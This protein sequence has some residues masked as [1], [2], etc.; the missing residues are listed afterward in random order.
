[1]EP[2]RKA[3]P[4]ILALI[5]N[6]PLVKL[7]RIRVKPGVEIWAK[8]ESFNPG[9]SVKDRIAL[10]MIEDAEQKGL[11]TPGK[12][13]AEASSG[14]T[15]I[16]LAMVCAVKGYRC[17]IAM[18]ESASVERRKIMQA[19]GAEI[20]LT[21]AEKSTDGAIEA[22]YEL[23]RRYPDKYYNPDQFNNPANWQMHYRTTGPEIWRDTEGRVTHVVASMGTTGTL[24]G[25][26]RYFREKAPG[27]RVIGVEPVPG[28][29]IQGLKNMKESYPPGIY[30]RKLP[31]AVVNVDDE[32]AYELARRLAREEGIFVGMSSG[33]ALAGALRVAREIEQGLIV[34]IFPDGGERYLS[35]PLWVFPAPPRREDF[36]I[37]NTLTGKK[38]VF[39][40]LEAGKVRIYTCGPTL[41]RRPHLGLYR[42]MLTADVLRRWLEARG[43][44]VTHVV[45]LTDFD[46]KTLAAA[47]A[48]GRPLRELT[49]E[50]AREF[51]EDLAFLRIKPAT[52]YPRVSEHLEDMLALTR[53]LLEKGL[54]YE[55]YSSVYFDVSKLPDYG[56]LSGVDPAGLKPGATVDLDEYEKDAPADFTLFKRVTIQELKQ[57][58]FVDTEWGKVRPG[59]HIQCAALA[60]KYLGETFDIH[61]SGTDLLFPHHENERAI[62]KALTGQELCRY[63]LHSAL[64]LVEGRK[65]S[66]S[67]G[68]EVT[69]A[70]LRRAGFSGREIRFFL[71]RTHYR[72]PLNFSW[73]ALSEARK[74]LSNLIL[75]CALLRT[76]PEGPPSGEA[77]EA[78]RALTE[79]F[80]AAMNDDL[81]VP[82]VLAELFRFSRRWYPLVVERGLPPTLREE[83]LSTLENVNRILEVLVFPEEARDEEVARILAEREAA[84][85]TG[86][87]EKADRLREELRRQGYLVVDT[88]RGSRAFRLP[89]E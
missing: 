82:Q 14:N 5:G 46:D 9:G 7:R 64:V 4:H 21:P 57:G 6:T 3:Q 26:A 75:F 17:L 48:S 29:K 50:L 13:V 73:Q 44:E 36:R 79:G 16:G 25:L 67:A 45:N 84:R 65:M 81:N 74:A 12:I 69:L 58:Y 22:I 32:E 35:T 39:E 71:L 30:D 66:V 15:G 27:V 63:W 10:S 11:L 55:K 41:N 40:P 78:L 72:K 53:R 33:A 20:L 18:P 49:E 52:H 28:H 37:T 77:E 87:Y 23:V 76:A 59:W 62:A 51:F 61:T 47:E 8:L 43:F 1:M 68:N 86:A 80:E 54:A 60:F 38:E 42:R 2:F 88:P 19:Y 34:V 70:D 24:M 31:H 83:A 89:D 56:R 85:K